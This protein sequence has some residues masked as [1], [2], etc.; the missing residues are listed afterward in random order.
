[1]KRL[2]LFVAIAFLWIGFIAHPARAVDGD[3]SSPEQLRSDL[4]QGARLFRRSPDPS[5]AKAFA[6]SL[7]YRDV[8]WEG[9]TL[10]V[11][12]P[13]LAD[14]VGELDGLAPEV[15]KKRLVEI[16]DH[17]AARAASVDAE[18]QDAAAAHP[19]STPK[20][21]STPVPVPTDP[22]A[23][24]QGI[25]DQHQFHGQTED[26]KLARAAAEVRDRIR[27]AWKQVKDFVGGLFEDKPQEKT[28]GSMLRQVGAV[29]VAVLGLIGGIWFL[30]RMV[31]RATTDGANDPDEIDL[32][33]EPPTPAL[34]TAQAAAL[35]ASGDRRGAVRALYLALLGE[36]HAQRVISYD[37]HRT[38]RE[39]LRSMRADATRAMQFGSVVDFFERKW[40]GRE[41]C[42]AEELEAFR[43]RVAR[44]GEIPER[45]AA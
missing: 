21:G 7:D 24:L 39:Y 27:S 33:E 41:E 9:R 2:A 23:V 29:I 18:L 31:M 8:S 14:R 19:G 25:L 10:T 44:T 38:N 15:R 11:R 5:A 30:A 35:A 43:G 1:V 22:D 28:F 13:W 12:D 34:M 32:P 20:A 16:A 36:L 40:Y 4:E 37:R 6:A 26:P 17:L 45:E 42:T 3:V